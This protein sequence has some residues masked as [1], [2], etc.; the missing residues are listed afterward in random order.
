MS[1]QN[2]SFKY[3]ISTLTFS[4]KQEEYPVFEGSVQL[5]FSATHDIYARCT[6]NGKKSTAVLCKNLSIPKLIHALGDV[7]EMKPSEI[8]PEV[9][10][11]NT[12]FDVYHVIALLVCYD[13]LT[14][15][16]WDISPEENVLSSPRGL[17]IV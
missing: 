7:G 12:A 1:V 14:P 13:D 2:I 15:K 16:K 8:I 9:Y 5:L 3:D 4:L 17:P 10:N 6:Y 11:K